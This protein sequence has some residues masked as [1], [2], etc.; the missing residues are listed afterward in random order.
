MS[1][2][3][4]TKL[5]FDEKLNELFRPTANQAFTTCNELRSVLVI[6]DYYGALNDTPGV[7]KGLWLSADGNS[8]R[9][10]DSIVG[11]VG[12]TLQCLAN[13]FDDMFARYQEL[14]QRLVVV[15]QEVLEK[16]QQ[17]SGSGAA[18]QGHAG[19]STM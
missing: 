11:S 6:F 19:S 7:S 15:S 9:A 17:L 14:Q 3:Q 18:G 4:Q 12:N 13:M 1:S 10:T 16:E 8:P 2:A 5:L